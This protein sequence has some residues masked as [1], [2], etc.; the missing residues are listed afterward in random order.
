MLLQFFISLRAEETLY[1]AGYNISSEYICSDFSV[2]PADTLVITRKLI[3]S[4]SFHLTGLYF[5]ETLPLQF[6]IIAHS[7]L[8]NGNALE[9][10]FPPPL[11]DSVIRGYDTYYWIID[12]PDSSGGIQNELAPGDSLVFELILSSVITG[13][14]EFP[15]H[16]SVF[17]GNNSGFFSTDN[18]IIITVTEPDQDTIPP[19]K[20]IDLGFFR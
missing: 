6:V 20:I 15:L 14:Y 11:T 7:I 1:P 17:Y 3:N 13:N 8:L 9:Y 16:T 5:S 2:G 19:A 4:E 18:E 12:D 10:S